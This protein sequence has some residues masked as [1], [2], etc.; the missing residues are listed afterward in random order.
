MF[1]EQPTSEETIFNEKRRDK[2]NK[3]LRKEKATGFT[4]DFSRAK[5]LP[6]DNE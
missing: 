4:S 5:I 6:E 3:S 2:I 1:S